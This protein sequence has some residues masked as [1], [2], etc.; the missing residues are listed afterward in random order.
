MGD[1]NRVRCSWW[2]RFA[3]LLWSPMIAVV[4]VG[5]IYEIPIHPERIWPG[6]SEVLDLT[7]PVLL[8]TV[9]P[10]FCWR[11]TW[12]SATRTPNGLRVRGVWRTHQTAW[13]DLLEVTSTELGSWQVLPRVFVISFSRTVLTCRHA[14]GYR[15]ERVIVSRSFRVG[16]AGRDTILSWLPADHPL[17][18]DLPTRPSAPSRELDRA[19]WRRLMVAGKFPAPA[20]RRATSVL[21]LVVMTMSVIAVAPVVTWRPI[22]LVGLICLV[23]AAAWTAHRIWT[24]RTAVTEAGLIDY[25]VLRTSVYPIEEI[26]GFGTSTNSGAV[27]THLVLWGRGSR[28]LVGAHRARAGDDDFAEILDQWLRSGGRLPADT[29]QLLGEG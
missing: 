19:A 10:W 18:P 15:R 26:R 11:F 6:Y 14:N 22:T 23:S 24:S 4:G 17:R 13:V 2:A 21:L 16:S 27:I 5:M 25:G 9:L 28:P 3:V 20:S 12:V 29:P 7:L 1:S 8:L